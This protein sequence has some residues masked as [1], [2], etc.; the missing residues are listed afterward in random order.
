MRFERVAA[1]SWDIDV[2]VISR[3]IW[4]GESPASR[5]IISTSSTKSAGASWRA[6]MLTLTANGSEPIRRCHDRTC[7]QAWLSTHRPISTGSSPLLGDRD[8]VVRPDPAAFGVLPADERLD[9]DHPTG[10]ISTSAGTGARTRGPRSHARGRPT[11]WARTMSGVVHRRSSN[12]TGRGPCRAPPESSTSRRRRCQ[13][14]RRPGRR[15]AGRPPRR[16]SPAR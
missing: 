2:S 5:M 8:E 7:W 12:P 16:R 13:A 14:G 9:A 15:P 11:S 6:E 1:L 4:V 3:T 10:R